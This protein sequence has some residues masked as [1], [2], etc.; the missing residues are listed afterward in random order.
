MKVVIVL[1]AAGY[2]GSEC[3]A[4]LNSA[5]YKVIG[6]DKV[7]PLY[8]PYEFIKH[9]LSKD[10]L[11]LGRRILDM[12]GGNSVEA[13]INFAAYKSLPDSVYNPLAYYENNLKVVMESL[14]MAKLLHPKKYI[15][16]SSA[17]VYSGIQNRA[18]KESDETNPKSPY[19]YSKLVGERIVMDT[20][21]NIGVI[22]VCLR[23]FN[24]AG[25]TDNTDDNS[26]SLFSKI[27]FILDE[28]HKG[29]I[30]IFGTD[31]DT[32]DGSCI[33]DYI[34]ISDLVDAH[35]FVIKNDDARGVLNVGTGKG[36]TVIEVVDAA[37]RIA[38]ANGLKF[39]YEKSSRRP[40]DSP[41]VYADT[42]K[43]M[44]LGWAPKYSVDDII[45]SFI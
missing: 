13:I 32:R 18:V 4:Q 8:Y 26:E 21:D 23:Y 5:G 2:I 12:V 24:P 28:D 25:R 42:S 15:F 37:C 33:R 44:S 35:L 45:E 27:A 6:I 41:I 9:D 34:H 3:S 1:G 40:G 38:H 10:G 11:E 36:T 39:N 7:E 30:K 29:S 22:P 20:C 17:S 14:E 16:S 31:Y 19:G 43:I